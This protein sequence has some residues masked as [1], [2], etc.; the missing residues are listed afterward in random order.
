[1]KI[2]APLISQGKLAFAL[3]FFL[4]AF[5]VCA[6]SLLAQQLPPAPKAGLTDVT[7]KGL[8]NEPAIAINPA[9]PQQLALAWQTNASVAYST[10]GGQS[11]VVAEGIA[12][13]DYRISGDVSITY[14]AAGHAVLCYIAFD[15]FGS[16]F[17][18]ARGATRN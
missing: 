18:W 7:P 12:P 13:K 14:D 6:G 9:N 3:S 8:F 10:D 15:N 5:A 11:W 1:M 16:L 2:T 17:Y 4:C